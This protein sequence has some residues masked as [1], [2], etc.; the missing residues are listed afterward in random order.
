MEDRISLEVITPGG[1]V[2]ETRAEYV[3]IP[4]ANGPIGVLAGHAPMYCALCEGKLRYRRADGEEGRADIRG[5]AARVGGNRVVVLT[6]EA[7]TD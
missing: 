5:G 6:P 7:E 2:L 4:A 1:T 3:S